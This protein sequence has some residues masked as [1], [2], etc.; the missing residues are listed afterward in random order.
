MSRFRQGGSALASLRFGDRQIREGKYQWCGGSPVLVSAML[1]SCRSASLQ[2]QYERKYQY[3][4]YDFYCRNRCIA[5]RQ[6]DV[7][8]DLICKSESRLSDKEGADEA[9]SERAVAWAERARCHREKGA[10]ERA[11]D[12]KEQIVPRCLCD[13]HVKE[14]TSSGVEGGD[15]QRCS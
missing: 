4:S 12:Q 2:R 10:T 7:S 13:D 8:F 6:V 3:A 9:G 15:G 11:G 1:P 14:L 5:G